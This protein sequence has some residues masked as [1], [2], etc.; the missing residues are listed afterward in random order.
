MN[1]VCNWE[2]DSAT[3]LVHNKKAIEAALFLSFIGYTGAVILGELKRG[4]RVSSTLL[5]V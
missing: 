3:H 2:N 1:R 5:S 4:T